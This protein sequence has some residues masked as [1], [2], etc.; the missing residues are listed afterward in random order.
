MIGRVQKTV[1]LELIL[2][3]TGERAFVQIKSQANNGDL[4]DYADRFD[5]ADLYDHMF[6][7]WQTGTVTARDAF[8]RITLVGP[9]RLSRMVLD[10]GLA[11]CLREKVS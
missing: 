11:S 6:F 5:Q 3:T 10:G 7:V 8:D 2:P 1:D 9:E 4:Q